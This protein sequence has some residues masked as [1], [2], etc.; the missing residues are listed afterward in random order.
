MKRRITRNTF[1]ITLGMFLCGGTV[2]LFVM[3]MDSVP[4]YAKQAVTKTHENPPMPCTKGAPGRRQFSLAMEWL[5]RLPPALTAMPRQMKMMIVKTL[6]NDNRYSIS[7][8]ALTK[9]MLK[10]HKSTSNDER[11]IPKW[12]SNNPVSQCD[13]NSNLINCR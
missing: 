1:L 13:L 12:Y 2:S 5:S 8:Y 4:P 10:R 11:H 9:T 3:G 6:S 7:P